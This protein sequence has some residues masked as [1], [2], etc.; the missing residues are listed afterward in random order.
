MNKIFPLFFFLF[1]F[2]NLCFCQEKNQTK[3]ISLL[4]DWKPNTNHTGFYVAKEK[5]FYS[6]NGLDLTIL[7]PTQTTTTTLVGTGRADFGISYANDVIYA[8][9]ANIPIVVLAA[10][11]QSDTSC[12]VWRK[13]AHISGPRDFEERRYGGWG[14]PEEIATLKYIM[15]KNHADFSKIKML[16][17]GMTDFLLATMKNVDFTWEYKAWGILN[18]QINHVA[19]ETYCPSEHFPE[20]NKPSPLLITNEKMIKEHPDLVKRFLLATEKGYEIAIKNPEQASQIL[21]KAIPE[22]DAHLVQ[23]S[24]QFLAPLYQGKAKHWGDLDKNKFEAYAQWMKQVGLI[25]AVPRTKDYLK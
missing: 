4:L 8:R 11:I 5:N 12:L 1:G 9:N 3:N 6:E 14:S 22:L 7:N 19:V 13:T 17:S 21:L 15:E 2:V 10:I 25:Q 18:A 16:N 23:T 24:A 20:L